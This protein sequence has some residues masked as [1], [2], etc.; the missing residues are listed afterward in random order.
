MS[1]SSD[2]G[3]WSSRFG[4]ILAG[5]GSAIGLGNIWRFPYITGQN[6]GAA[7]VLIYL[8]CVFLIGYP[9]MIAELT[10]GRSAQRNPVGV[11]KVIK[12]NS[13][14][15]YVGGLSVL[16]G[17]MIFSW[18]CVVAGWIVGYL[19]KTAIGTF[20]NPVDTGAIFDEFV[21]DPVAVI[22]LTLLF[23]IL[24]GFVVFK[25]VSSGIERWS[26]VLMPMLL[27]LLVLLAI[28]S[29]TLE[30]A[31]EGLVFYLKPDFSKVNINVILAAMGQALFSLSLGMGIMVTY[32]SYLSKKDNIST[33]A[34]WVCFFDTSIAMLSG[35]VIL[36]A[37]AAMG[38][39][40][41]EGPGL[42][43]QVL[44]GI[45]GDMP[46]GQLFGIGLFLLII[47]AAITS[48]I[49]LL[50]VNVAY[51]VDEK[52]MSRK[53]SVTLVCTLAFFISIPAALA[54][55]ANA[56]LSRL[57]IIDWDYFTFISTLFGDITIAI[58]SLL[59][60][61]FVGWSWKTSHAKKEIESENIRFRFEG[62]WNVLIR[63]VSPVSVL[64][65][66]LYTFWSTFFS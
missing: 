12:Q 1:L 37:V 15:K 61:L 50:E 55:G 20:N 27:V 24:T 57:P 60:A 17:F 59:I 11:F 31:F 43:F 49:S 7:F 35:F 64:L 56:F 28:R 39:E 14:W 54:S 48:T 53:K 23:V 4:F 38:Q 16:T 44:P 32:G 5:A 8:L 30:G 3:L 22:F 42:V 29:I 18:Y 66:F 51:L 34:A 58:G 65:V 2:R 41:S 26:R 40:Y 63:Y 25:G 9:V 62:I 33:S 52:K 10:L 21:A 13:S 19:Y 6:G 45:F 46:G 47:I 36:P